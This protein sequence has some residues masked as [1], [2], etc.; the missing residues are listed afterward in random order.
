[1]GKSKISSYGPNGETYNPTL[2]AP[3]DHNADDDAEALRKAMKGLGTDEQG[4]IDILG[5][6]DI[7]QRLE[8]RDRYK[9]L[10]GKELIEVISSETSGDF[11][12]LLKILLLEIPKV[13]ARALYKAMKGG[14][15]DE[16][17]IIEI[18]CTSTNQEIL[19][20]RQFYP[21]VLMD[22]GGD[23]SRTLEDDVKDDIGGYFGD[24]IVALLQAE[25]DEVDLEDVKKIA[26]KGLQSVVDMN[27]VREDVDTLWDA[28]EAHLGTDESAIIKV[29]ANRSVWHIQA[30]AQLYEQTYGKSL[31][32]SIEF[33]TSGD[34]KRALVLTIR[35]CINRPKAYADLLAK[36]MKGAGTDDATLMRIIATRCEIDLGSI[37][38]VF[39]REQGSSLEDWVRSETSGDYCALLLALL[40]TE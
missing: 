28:G 35:T 9:A 17:T 3:E 18:L 26:S 5:H 12:R 7:F 39:Q 33:E 38:E 25:R 24:F 31:I 8:I 37:C 29:V 27:L 11:R 40:G 13:N 32:D 34:F 21:Y 20:I 2:R 4:L 19:E 6:R 1:M 14:G 30:V 22:Y 36:A 23:S 16:E 10:Y 15:T